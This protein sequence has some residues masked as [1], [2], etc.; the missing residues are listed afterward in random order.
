MDFDKILRVIVS[1]II[2]IVLIFAVVQAFFTIAR[3]LFEIIILVVWGFIGYIL[4]KLLEG[5]WK[6]KKVGK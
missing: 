2:L 5:V 4:I 6:N 3:I 1:I